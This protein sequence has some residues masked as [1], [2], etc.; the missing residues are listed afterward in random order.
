MIGAL[1]EGWGFPTR[2]QGD[3]IIIHSRFIQLIRRTFKD[4]IKLYQAISE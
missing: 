1:G 3:F 2:A 4:L